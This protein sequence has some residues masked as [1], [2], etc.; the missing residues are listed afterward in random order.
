MG[1]CACAT[2]SA[3]LCA[4]PQ[5]CAFAHPVGAAA[6]GAVRV[7]G[8]VAIAPIRATVRVIERQPIRSLLRRAHCGAG[9]CGR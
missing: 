2:G 9:G 4:D 7:V 3:C 8:R 6:R 5:A 1:G